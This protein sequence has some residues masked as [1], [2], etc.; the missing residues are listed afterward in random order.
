MKLTQSQFD[1]LSKMGVTPASFLSAFGAACY[2]SNSFDDIIDFATATPD[3]TDLLD[4]GITVRQWRDG[5]KEAL[6]FAM[7]N[8]SGYW[9][10]VG[11]DEP[12]ADENGY[13]WVPSSAEL[14]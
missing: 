7:K 4:W 10:F 3:A 9:L 1:Q 13:V 12:D 6:S 8:F 11:E 5:Q 14:S 2:D